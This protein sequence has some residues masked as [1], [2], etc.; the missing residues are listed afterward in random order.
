MSADQAQSHGLLDLLDTGVEIFVRPPGTRL[1]N[2]TL[3]SG[4][5]K[6][7]AAVSPA[8]L[9]GRIDFVRNTDGGFSVMELE[10]IEPSLYLRMDPEAPMRFARALVEWFEAGVEGEHE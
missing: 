8:P 6:A 10:L 2:V 1:S 5:Q 9:Y 7:M 4:G 3:L